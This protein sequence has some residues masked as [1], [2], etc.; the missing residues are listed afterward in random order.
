MFFVFLLLTDNAQNTPLEVY[1]FETN[2]TKVVLLLGL[3][4]N[5]GYLYSGPNLFT[6]EIFTYEK[7]EHIIIRKFDPKYSL[8]TRI[9]TLSI[10]GKLL[11]SANGLRFR[12]VR[13]SKQ[14]RLIDKY[15]IPMADNGFYKF[16]LERLK[17][18]SSN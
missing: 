10:K 15:V 11:C 14:K 7:E 12:K 17:S 4:C 2:G 16:F 8:K 9:D 1:K 18:C 3:G 5:Q 6:D 13:S